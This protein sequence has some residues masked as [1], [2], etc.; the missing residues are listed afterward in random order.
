MRQLRPVRLEIGLTTSDPTDCPAFAASIQRAT[1]VDV[2]ACS[3]YKKAI[4]G[5][6]SWK[7]APSTASNNNNAASFR[8][9][10]PWTQ[11]IREEDLAPWS[12]FLLK[13][14]RMQGVTTNKIVGLRVHVLAR[15]VTCQALVRLCQLFVKYET[16]LDA[17]VPE[18]RRTDSVASAKYFQSNAAALG[19]CRQSSNTSSVSLQKQQIQKIEDCTNTESLIEVFCPRG[20]CYKLNLRNARGDVDSFVEF[21]QHSSTSNAAK[22]HHWMSLCLGLVDRAT[23]HTKSPMAC[24]SSRTLE[25]QFDTLFASALPS[26]VALRSFFDQRRRALSSPIARNEPRKR[27]KSKSSSLKKKTSGNKKDDRMCGCCFQ[28]ISGKSPVCSCQD[29]GH[30]F[31]AACVKKYAKQEVFTNHNGK[32]VCLAMGGDCKSEYNTRQLEAVLP[33]A[34]RLKLRELQYIQENV[35]QKGKAFCECPKCG[36]KGMV[37]STEKTFSCPLGS[38]RFHSCRR[39]KEEAHPNLKCSQVE[40]Q[41]VRNGRVGVEEAMTNQLIRKC[42]QCQTPTVL[43]SGCN[44]MT[45]TVCHT[46]FC[47]QCRQRNCIGGCSTYAQDIS[48]RQAVQRAGNN[49]LN[50]LE[51]NTVRRELAGTV[52]RLL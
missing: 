4:S 33:K 30:L 12:Q 49:A 9:V 36:S 34:T 1:S 14:E 22:M 19:C 29:A 50:Q 26:E 32:L 46:R 17:L 11:S 28:K 15:G 25:E 35:Q 41:T 27:S 37:P 39:C 23:T 45:C 52:E 18:S 21:R 20:S 7:L 31:C 13:V 38:C 47:F 44:H 2:L 43:G 5:D 8:L 6:T 16:V 10:S 3:T 24:R 40:Q 42:P 51:N 48:D